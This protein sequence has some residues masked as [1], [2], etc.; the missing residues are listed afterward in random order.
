M[1]SLGIDI[2]A[3]ITKIHTMTD[4]S[5]TATE[6]KNRFADLVDM[7]RTEP[8]TITRNDRAV[9]IVLSPTEYARLMA[10]DDAYWGEQ[11]KRLNADDFLSVRESQNI[12]NSMLNASDHAA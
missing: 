3:N 5:I 10:S 6:A 7:A 8:V 4:K 9:A 11:A 12:L 1:Y 2:L